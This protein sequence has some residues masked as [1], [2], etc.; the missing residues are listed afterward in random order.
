[1]FKKQK[2]YFLGLCI[3]LCIIFGTYTAFYKSDD[4]I[5]DE[6]VAFSP[7]KECENIIIKLIEH[8]DK[9]D[10]AVFD[11]NNDNIVDALKKAEKQGKKN[12]NID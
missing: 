9:I 7:S 12:Q 3:G 11:I 5:F 2:S 4:L 8:A 1:M 6:Q 10:I